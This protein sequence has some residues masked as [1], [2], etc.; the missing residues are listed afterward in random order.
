MSMAASSSAAAITT[1]A[2]TSNKTASGELFYSWL[3][4]KIQSLNYSYLI[5]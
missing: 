1:A 3:S 5:S 2:M 4:A